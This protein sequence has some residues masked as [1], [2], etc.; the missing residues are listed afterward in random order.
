MRGV[1][2]PW[3]PCVSSSTRILR[4]PAYPPNSEW[5]EHLVRCAIMTNGFSD[6][7]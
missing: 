2:F 3:D 6:Q 1:S 7:S 5:Q 4:P